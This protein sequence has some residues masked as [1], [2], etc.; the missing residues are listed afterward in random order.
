MRNRWAFYLMSIVSLGTLGGIFAARGQT[1][2]GIGFG[3]IALAYL[4]RGL[5]LQRRENVEHRE[6]IVTSMADRKTSAEKRVI[7]QNL[8]DTRQ[9][10]KRRRVSELT[11]GLIVLAGIVLVYPT[12]PLL[13]WSFSVLFLP[14]IFLIV[15]QTRSIQLIERGLAERGMLPQDRR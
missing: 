3:A 9:Q 2:W 10:L 13:A 14:L 8:L 11:L 15:R 12:N 1:G 4:I 6:A 7:V 5:Y